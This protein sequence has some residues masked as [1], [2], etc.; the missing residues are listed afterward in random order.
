MVYVPTSPPKQASLEA[1]DLARDIEGV[2]AA[3][4]ERYP[5]TT[6]DD[7]RQAVLLAQTRCGKT[8]QAAPAIVASA[9]GASMLIGM[10]TFFVARGGGEI[11]WIAIASGGILVVALVAM[12]LAVRQS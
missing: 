9:I 12:I 3:Y 7:I 5:R 8:S 6:Q 11:P 10:A 4:Q 2:I 1:Q